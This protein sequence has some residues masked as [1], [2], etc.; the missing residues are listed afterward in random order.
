MKTLM[1]ILLSMC[2]FSFSG[3]AGA[4]NELQLADN[5]TSVQKAATTKATDHWTS[6]YPGSDTNKI[7]CVCDVLRP[8]GSSINKNGCVNGCN[9]EWVSPY[10]LRCM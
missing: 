10:N 5:S 3:L 7:K 1:S 4:N 8:E 6:C 9:A 2:V